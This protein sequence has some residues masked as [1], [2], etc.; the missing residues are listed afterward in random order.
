MV[1]C[2][3]ICADDSRSTT[4]LGATYGYELN[5]K[6]RQK[7]LAATTSA[8]DTAQDDYFGFS[9]AVGSGRIVVGAP[10]NDDTALDSGNA[11]IYDLDGRIVKK[12]VASDAGADDEFGYSVAVGSV[13]IVVGSP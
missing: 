11:Y 3:A 7:L 2:A 6:F 8:S 4:L 5:G 10:Y 1:V 13:R 9:V 12:I